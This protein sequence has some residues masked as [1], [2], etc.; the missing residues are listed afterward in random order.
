MNAALD[1]FQNNRL[2]CVLQDVTQVVRPVSSSE[3]GAIDELFASNPPLGFVHPCYIRGVDLRKRSVT[4]LPGPAS[5]VFFR[6]DTAQSAGI[7]YSDLIGFK[8]DRLVAAKWCSQQSEPV[9]D[10]RTKSLF[11]MMAHMWLR[12]AMWLPEKPVDREKKGSACRWQKGNAGRVLL[13]L[14]ACQRVRWTVCRD[15]NHLSFLLRKIASN[16]S[17]VRR[18][19]PG[20]RIH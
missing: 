3:I 18:L 9:N 2:I 5:G 14:D 11:E 19:D 4:P 8:R 15:G 20:P 16:V 13:F 10:K 7:N 12:F 1:L 6:E 17:P